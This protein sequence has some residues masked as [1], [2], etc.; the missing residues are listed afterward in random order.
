M[1]YISD[2][3]EK[4]QFA[5]VE[6]LLRQ[7]YWAGEREIS[8]LPQSIENSLCF[9]VYLNE[10]GQQIAF[11][12]VVTD[13][14]TTFYLCDVIVDEKYRSMGIGKALIERI[15]YDDRLRQLKG[16]LKTSDAHGLYEKY[17]F[18][19]ADANRFVYRQPQ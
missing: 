15:V 19:G 16:M 10:S 6:Q 5:A 3:K 13:Y 17:G 11:A 14:T 2:E 7:S 8:L 18:C 9:G 12:R 1:F 4:I